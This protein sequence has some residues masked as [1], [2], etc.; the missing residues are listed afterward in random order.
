[1]TY[2]IFRSN[3]YFI[4]I[5]ERGNYYEEECENVLVTKKK[6]ADDVYKVA[7]LRQE[8]ERMNDLSQSFPDISFSNITDELGNPYASVAAWEA[9]YT[10]NT[11]QGY[12]ALA[13]VSSGLATEATLQGLSSQART[14]GIIRTTGSGSISFLVYDFS[15]SNVGAANGTLL[16]Q[17]LKPGETVNFDG[18]AINN[19]Y[20]AGTV[21]YDAT[22]T[23]FL[24]IY[25]S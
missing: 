11:G 25:N 17:T 4:L 1:M 22:G 12:I 7:F 15:V 16:G 18:G 20:P 23:E 5:D 2:K 3:N 14:P 8:T 21:T 10:Q 13:M 19:Y 9:F 24:I 6:E